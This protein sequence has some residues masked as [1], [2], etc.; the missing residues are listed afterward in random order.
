MSALAAGLAALAALSLTLAIAGWL[1][2]ERDPRP[3]RPARAGRSLSAADRRNLVIGL[4]VGVVLALFGW[5]IALVIAPAVAV[6]APRLMRAPDQVDPERLEAMAEWARSLSGV[7]GANLGLAT[8]IRGT[9]GSLP[10]PIR[11]ELERLI[12]RLQARRPLVESLYAF[13][14]DLHDQTGDYIASAM[15]GAATASGAGLR[16]TLADIAAD[17]ASEVRVR[18]EIATARRATTTQVRLITMFV[19]AGVAGY[20]LFTPLG[21]QYQ[22]GIGQLLLAA[23][24]VLFALCLRWIR[25]AGSTTPPA[26]FLSQP[27]RTPEDAR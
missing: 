20:V 27:T 21:Q 8:A 10:E 5:I 17:T 9:R 1:P 13:A 25:A 3:T 4:A 11:P 12:A 26:R 19:V 16:A 6:A 15:I 18:R 22:H 14:D 2:R 24:C 23:Y 7:V